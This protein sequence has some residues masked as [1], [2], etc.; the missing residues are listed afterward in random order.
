MEQA[1][2]R[3]I[4]S[5]AQPAPSAFALGAVRRR[6]RLK[7]QQRHLSGP[8]SVARRRTAARGTG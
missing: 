7:K 4:V 3:M 6:S 8:P 1:A 5:A 2:S